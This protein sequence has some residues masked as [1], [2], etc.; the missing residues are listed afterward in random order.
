MEINEY[1]V[2]F[3]QI[4]KEMESLD[5]FMVGAKLS[6]TE[7]RLLR[8]II[9]EGE[10]G[11]KIISSELARRLG[12]TRSAVSQIVSKMEERGILQRVDSPTDKKIAYI[13][14]SERA[15]AVFEEQCKQANSIMEQVV[16]RLGEEKTNGLIRT[17]DEFAS[18]LASVRGEMDE[19]SL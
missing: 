7:F 17:Y 19:K 11:Q 18:T 13:Q 16:Q 12:V 6:K 5:F 14:L 9:M 4:V 3:I 15:Y 10:K 2:K 1:L 8:E